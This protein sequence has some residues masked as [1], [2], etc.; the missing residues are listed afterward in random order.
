M[1][2]DNIVAEVGANGFSWVPNVFSQKEINQIKQNLSSYVDAKHDGMVYESDQKTIRGIHG[3]HLFD[4][5]FADLCR[6]PALLKTAMGHLN[7]PCY[8]HQFK[9]NSKKSKVGKAW[10]W[11]QDFIFWQRGDGFKEQK[12]LNIGVLLD[13]VELESGPLCFIPKSH[14][15]GELTDV[16]VPDG[17]WDQDVSEQLSYT[18]SEKVSSNLINIY[19]KRYI[20]GNAGDIIV[21]DPQV[22]HSSQPNTS[23]NDRQLLLITYN[24]ISNRPESRSPRPDF[25]C[26][27]DIKELKLEECD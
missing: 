13:D 16:E 2:V 3:L 21:F 15:L 27:K 24:A 7:E 20:T 4:E 11:H 19:G 25:L 5:F 17:G 12:L 18:I 9:V 14:L 23:L 10:P 1:K 26:T 6:H 8:V 22:V